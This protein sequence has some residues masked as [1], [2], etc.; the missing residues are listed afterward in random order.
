MS[1]L[2]DA[3]S[4]TTFEGQERRARKGKGPAQES[5]IKLATPKANKL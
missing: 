3:I 5:I 1:L 4:E 2:E